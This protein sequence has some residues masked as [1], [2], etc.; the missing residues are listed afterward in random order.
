MADMAAGEREKRDAFV[1]RMLSSTIGALELLHV[2]LGERLGLYRALSN[3]GPLTAAG[4]ASAAGI[5]ERYA[6]EWLEEQ[7]VAG[8]LAVEPG[9]GAEAERRFSLPREHAEVLD[10]PDSVNFLAPV[11]RALV[12]IGSVM[13]LVAEAFRTGGGVPYE[14][15][16]SEMRGSIAALNRPMFLNLLGSQWFPAITDV[17]RRLRSHPPAR[18]A[19]VGCGTGWSSIAIA[20]AYPLVSVD[21]FDLDPASVEDAQGNARERGISDRVSFEVRDAADPRLAGAYDLVT[22][23]ETIHDMS[24]PVGALRA[25][26]ALARD[27]GAVV[28]VDEKAALE[29]TAPGDELERF[30]YGWSAI[31]CLPVGM[32]DSP[33]AGT[34][35]VMRPSRLREYARAAGFED[36]EILPVETDSWRFYRLV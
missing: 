21:G 10:D 35:T 3:A 31:H 25:M 28:V 34:G 20:A 14:A 7:A 32:V 30:L 17:D 1:G 11:G 12:G 6:R 5:N 16:G 15:Y 8:I 18:V 13:P 23:F 4:L 9:A 27:G 2:Y 19:D 33:S 29:F 26:R 36:V 22:A 24:N